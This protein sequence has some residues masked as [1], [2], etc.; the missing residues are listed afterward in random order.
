MC[1]LGK[2]GID[3]PAV[4]SCQTSEFLILMQRWL[5]CEAVDVALAMGVKAGPRGVW[6]FN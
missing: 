6:G 5:F 3:F 1:V 2:N 4:S